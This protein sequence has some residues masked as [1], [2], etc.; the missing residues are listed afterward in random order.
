MSL[1]LRPITQAEAKAFVQERHRH[2][3]APVGS[4]WQHAV[5]DEASGRIVGVAIVGRPVSRALDDGFTA[6]VTR[7]C[8]DGAANACSMLYGAARR[9]AVAK[10]YVR[11]ITY[12][13]ASESGASLR[14]AGWRRLW[15]VRGRSWNC[16]TRA[17]VD[18]HPTEDKVAFGWGDW[19]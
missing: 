17:R 14:A 10:G 8:T 1:R 11:G 18:K 13:L 19:P 9:A 3:R 15:D 7:L 12:I 6:E 4:L 2:H 5:Q 16:P